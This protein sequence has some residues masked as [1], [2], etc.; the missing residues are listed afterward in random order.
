MQ[1]AAIIDA[2]KIVSV[3]AKIDEVVR[4]S[5]SLVPAIA[6]T[7]TVHVIVACLHAVSS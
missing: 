7:I 3:L 4:W 6:L 5:W 2:L 1:I